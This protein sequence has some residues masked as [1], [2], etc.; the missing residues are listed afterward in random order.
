MNKVEAVIRPEKL[1]DVRNVLLARGVS[2]M[3]VSEVKG[4]GRQRG[5]QYSY[6]GAHYEVHFLKKV[7]IEVAVTEEMTN[8]VV[9]AL[10]N[11]AR[12]GAVGD[13]K[14]FVTPLS[15]V[16]RVRTGEEGTAALTDS[17]EAMAALN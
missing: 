14:I 11:V 9:D 10:I 17:V 15:R 7:K 1:E 5:N 12:T 8:T 16:I 13:G 4:F 2:G 3:T 6:R